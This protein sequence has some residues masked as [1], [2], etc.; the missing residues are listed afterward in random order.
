M[1]MISQK[2]GPALILTAGRAR[3]SF[4]TLADGA[5]RESNLKFEPELIGQF[6]PRP[7]L[8]SRLPFGRSN[9]GSRPRLGIFRLVSI[10]NARTGGM[11][12]DGSRSEWLVSRSPKRCASRRGE[13][14][15][16]IRGDRQ[17]SLA[18]LSSRVPGIRPAA[19][20]RTDSRRPK[21]VRLRQAAA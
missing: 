2:G 12:F 14:V 11:Q 21:A 9:I 19:Y 15:S 1:G 3:Q 10:S 8:D 20:V 16:K 7:R 17:L 4:D 6:A 5:W 13:R 18:Q